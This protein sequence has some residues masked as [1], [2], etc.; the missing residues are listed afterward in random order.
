M[1]SQAPLEREDRRANN[2]N[3]LIRHAGN[4]GQLPGL[5]ERERGVTP[6]PTTPVFGFSAAD[7]IVETSSANKAWVGFAAPLGPSGGTISVFG[8]FSPSVGGEEIEGIT[9]SAIA[10]IGVPEP[11]SFA[12]LGV[13]ILGLVGLGQRRGKL[14]ATPPAEP[15]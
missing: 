11:A 6:P 3:G 5:V 1:R 10:L 13:G 4:L 9:G 8:A 2:L 7:I 12:V 14:L 15:A